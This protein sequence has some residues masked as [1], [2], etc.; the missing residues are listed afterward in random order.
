MKAVTMSERGSRGGLA[1][2]VRCVE[3][4]PEPEGPGPGEVLIRTECSA[5]NQLDLWLGIGVPGVDRPYPLVS[6]CDGCGRVQSVGF[7]VDESWIGERV[8]FNAAVPQL[9][10]EKPGQAPADP[11]VP[12]LHLIGEH[13]QGAHAERFVAP[14]ANL[15]A[16]GEVAPEAAAAFGLTFLTAYSMMVT[17]GGLLPGQT[18]LVTGIGGGVATAA[19][20]IARWRGCRVVVTSRHAHKLEAAGALG[21]EAGILDAG[22][23]WSRQVRTLTQKRGVDMVVDTIGG[24][25]HLWC[26]KSLARGGTLVTAGATAAPSAQTDLARIFWNQLRIL[27]STM[28]SNEEFF[29]L[30]ALLKQGH[31][32]P[33][34]DRVFDWKEAAD[35]YARLEQGEQ[36]GKI[37]LRWDG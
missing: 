24:E 7:G 35:A 31:L 10:D 6:G 21:A 18:V 5:L 34:V 16:V 1:A 33:V 13:C 11:R 30:A 32:V 25:L 12:E 2:L 22:E 14:V 23:D 17:K 27:G 9:I 29:Q 19:L 3:D 26:I 4:W 36:M 37:V 20:A 28:G 15:A 8:I